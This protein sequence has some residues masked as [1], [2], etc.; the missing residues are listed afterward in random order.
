VR[1]AATALL[2]AAIGCGSLTATDDGVAF[3]EVVRPVS[4]TLDIGQTLQLE[5]RA[6]DA[7]GQPVAAVIL[8]ASADPFLSV[9]EA[10]GLVTAL[11]GG[12]GGRIQARTG[13]GSGAL[14]SDFLLL[15][16]PLPPVNASPPR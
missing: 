4:T 3:L 15:T 7:R 16:V 5:A 11:A 13:T 2:L 10:T 12:T 9:D 8:W 14:F 6:L 1:A